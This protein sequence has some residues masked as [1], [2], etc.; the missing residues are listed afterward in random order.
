MPPLKDGVIFLTGQT[1]TCKREVAEGIALRL[2]KEKNLPLDLNNTFTRQLVQIHQVEDYL[3]VD[4]PEYL[5]SYNPRMRQEQWDRAIDK[6]RLRLDPVPE[7]TLLLFHCVHYRN[8]RIFSQLNWDRLTAFRPR[9]I[10]TLIDDIY[11]I[12]ER[13]RS[14]EA[15]FKT[16]SVVTLEEV[17]LWRT[18]EIAATK[19]L[20]RNLFVDPSAY[21]DVERT[22]RASEIRDAPFFGQPIEHFVVSAKQT[23]EMLYRLCFEPDRLRVYASYP[24]SSPRS[25]AA[26]RDEI[27]E[28]RAR[29]SERFVVFDPLAIDELRTG[30]SS[31]WQNAVRDFGLLPPRWPVSTTPPVGPPATAETV[32]THNPFARWNPQSETYV[33]L[34]VP[35]IMNIR[36]A[37]ERQIVERDFLLVSQG[38]TVAVYRPFFGARSEPTGG[39]GEEMIFASQI[40]LPL[41]V[42]HPQDDDNPAQSTFFRDMGSRARLTT[43]PSAATRR[44]ELGTP[45]RLID[46]L[47]EHLL[48][49]ESKKRRGSVK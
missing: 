15:E 11:D 27:N 39:V 3:G 31:D 33:P 22:I 41:V 13:I 44:G 32:P 47:I 43:F 28:Y 21:P 19:Q 38:G 49:Y 12:W 40:P 48:R 10:I 9:L 18:F 36:R 20:A 34:S 8:G 25:S 16:R 42:Y 2:A 14:R 37:I 26:A 35:E 7:F 29:L 24:I 1:G 45:L 6:V 23:I 5:D 17:L 30:S 46:E 4:L